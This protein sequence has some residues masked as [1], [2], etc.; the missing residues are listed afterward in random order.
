MGNMLFAA[1][2]LLLVVVYGVNKFRSKRKYN[3]KK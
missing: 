1:L 2:A 3:R